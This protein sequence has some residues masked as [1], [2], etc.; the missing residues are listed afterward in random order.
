MSRPKRAG[1]PFAA[2]PRPRRPQCPA[3]FDD[4]TVRVVKENAATLKVKTA[5][6][7]AE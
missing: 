3:G 4:K 2:R 1:F 5:E 6:F 7:E